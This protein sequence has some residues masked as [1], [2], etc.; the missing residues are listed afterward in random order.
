MAVWSLSGLRVGALE[1]GAQPQRNRSIHLY[2]VLRL[3]S[4]RRANSA[5]LSSCNMYSSMNF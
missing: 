3:I 2:A 4:K 1:R 5:M